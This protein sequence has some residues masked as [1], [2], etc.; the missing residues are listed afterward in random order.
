MDPRVKDTVQVSPDH[1]KVMVC[2]GQKTGST[3]EEIAVLSDLLVER[4]IEVLDDLINC[5][6]AKDED[7]EYFELTDR[8]IDMW[9][10]VVNQVKALD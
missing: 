9:R 10:A 3:A 1:L 4:V 6:V 2:L 8:G 5:G 7:A